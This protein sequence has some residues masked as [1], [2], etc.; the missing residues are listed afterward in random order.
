MEY[1]LSVL[2]TTFSHIPPTPTHPFLHLPFLSLSSSLFPHLLLP[3]SFPHHILAPLPSFLSLF[4]PSPQSSLYIP[5]SP[6]LSHLPS[7]S[8]EKDTGD[9]DQDKRLDR[10][11]H[12]LAAVGR[13]S[14]SKMLEHTRYV[15]SDC[16]C[17]VTQCKQN[18]GCRG[19]KRYFLELHGEDEEKKEEV[20]GGGKEEGRECAWPRHC[21][22]FPPS[23]FRLWTFDNLIF[24]SLTRCCDGSCVCLRPAHWRSRVKILQSSL[25]CMVQ[26]TH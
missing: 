16:G 8:R 17:D 21:F 12:I 10:P 11:W 25:Q 2:M 18:C 9:H 22:S 14:G 20:G 7:F 23:F 1:K 26:G 13:V 4:H 15:A 3:S 6:L 19:Y 5:P 24:F